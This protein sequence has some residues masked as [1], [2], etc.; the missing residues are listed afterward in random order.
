MYYDLHIHSCLS[1]CG[2]DEMTINNICNMAI[3]KGLDLISIT[4]H[5]S[6]LNLR[7]LKKISE[8]TGIKIIYGVEVQTIEE[9]HI[10]G[11]F[12]TLEEILVFQKWL[13]D[14]IIKTKNKPEY[15]GNQLI[16]DENDK[17]INSYD[18]LLL[19]SINC[20]IEECCKTIHKYGG[21]VVLAHVV[22]RT[23]SIC[24][25]LGF[26]PKNLK[27]DGIEIK[28]FE[29]KEKVENIHPWLKNKF[30]FIN[31]DA[32][33]LIDISERENFISKESLNEFWR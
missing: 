2:N 9:V 23:N 24:T 12:K 11:Y 29:Q 14:N 3:I 31:S 32:H 6:T 16:V 8:S 10:L 7:A 21:K 15:F 28:N 33:Q 30:W 18:N 4:D 19:M 27:F 22:D 1:P 17:V 5:N 25:Q 13:D 26:I 20:N